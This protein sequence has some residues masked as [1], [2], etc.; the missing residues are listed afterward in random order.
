MVKVGSVGV[1][2]AS[3]VADYDVVVQHVK[4]EGDSF[5]CCIPKIGFSMHVAAMSRVECG[6]CL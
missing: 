6:C 3:Q 4:F 1:A 2:P 5:S